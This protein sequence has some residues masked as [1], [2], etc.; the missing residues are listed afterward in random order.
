MIYINKI[1]IK[2]NMLILS[3]ILILRFL[4]KM[5][6]ALK[7]KRNPRLNRMLYKKLLKPHL[8]EL[9]REMRLV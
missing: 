2:M 6:R 5:S 3:M 1:I 4:L 7:Y 8:K 9:K